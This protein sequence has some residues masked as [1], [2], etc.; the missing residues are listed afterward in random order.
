M[1]RR[2]VALALVLAGL[3]CGP[4]IPPKPAGVP[5]TAFWAGDGKAGVFVA[6]GV[7]DH[8]G[9]QVQLYDDRSGA[10][11]AQGL[12]VIHQGTARPS[13]KQE[14]FAG[15]D[16]HAVRLTGGGVLEPKTR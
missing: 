16:G 10:V 4:R 11:V 2:S 13:F 8:E 14:D 12:Y 9:W 5:A 1:I 6:I 15:W 7:P 3:A